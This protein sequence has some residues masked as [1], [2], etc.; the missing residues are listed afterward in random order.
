MTDQ[1]NP[2]ICAACGFRI[3]IPRQIFKLECGH[4]IHMT[5]AVVHYREY[6]ICLSCQQELSS[7]DRSI[8]EHF[9]NLNDSEPS[10]CIHCCFPID[11]PTQRFELQ[12][13][14]V[15]H[16]MCAV[17]LQQDY[18]KCTR[19]NKMLSKDDEESLEALEESERNV[20]K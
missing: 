17:L 15:L 10:R 4:F 3:D 20:I 1:N 12:C 7:K 14:H 19:C 6:N 16:F 2:K 13:G 5:C 11:V 18:G 8:I 9:K